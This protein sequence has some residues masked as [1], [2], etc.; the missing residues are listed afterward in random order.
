MGKFNIA[1]NNKTVNLAGGQAYKQTDKLEFTTI[2]LTSFL[3]NK[4]YERAD[5][6]QKRLTDLI[7]GMS[8][9]KFLAKAA[10]YARNEFGMRSVSH[11]VAGEIAKSVKGEPWTKSF[12]DKIIRRPDDMGEILSYYFSAGNKAV[13]NSVKKGF[14]TAFQRFSGYQ[15]AK[16]RGEGKGLNLMDIANLVHPKSNENITKLMKGELKST[17]TWEAKLSA[18]KGDEVAKTA[19]WRDLILERKIGY[20]ALLRNLRNILQQAPDVADKACELLA[21]EKLIRNSLVFP[22]RYQTALKELQQVSGSSKILI[23][24]NKA[25]D[26]SVKNVPTF[27]G[28]TL[29]ALDISASME[30]KP[31]EIASL[32]TAILLKSNPDAEL[33]VFKDEANYVSINPM[34]STLTI[35]NSLKFQSGGTNFHSIFQEANKA[36]SRIVILSDMQGWIGHDTPIREFNTYCQKFSCNPKIYSFDLQGYGTMQFPQNNIYC[37]AGFSEKVFDIMRLFEQDKNA[38]ITT[39]ESIEL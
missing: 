9:K 26:V 25:L 38:L 6:T 22:F 16:Y 11:L 15:L 30:G 3:K 28:K 2:L 39:I 27:E 14:A 20:F 21:D 32:F 35:A 7:L 13:P 17:E 36:Y 10:L 34:D 33:L 18:T 4:F 37:L 1:V 29:I 19:A 23:A 5:E 12:F 24:L 8:D 31:A